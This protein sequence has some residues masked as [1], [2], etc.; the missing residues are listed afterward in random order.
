MTSLR[1]IT[2][3]TAEPVSLETVKEHLR[4]DHA[5]EDALL[6]T[7]IAGARESGEDLARRAFITQTLEMTVDAWPED[8][9]LTLWRPP[10]QSVTS[11]KYY[12]ADDVQHTWTD[13][14]VDTDSTPGAVAFNTLPGDS[15]R[16]SGAITVRFV[17][18]YGN[19]EANV[20]GTIR[21]AL[22]ALIAYRYENRLSADIPRDIRDV[23]VG[24]RVVWF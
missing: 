16:E 2:P 24:E 9:I 5:Y 13:Y 17:A 18:G 4:I 1:V 10:L 23:F 7:Y 6:D 14:T 20:P 8:G 15:L 22:L 12:D 3:P 11:V 19:S 21:N